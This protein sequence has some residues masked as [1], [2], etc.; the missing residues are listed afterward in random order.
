MMRSAPFICFSKAELY[1][2]ALCAIGRGFRGGFKPY[3]FSEST[4]LSGIPIASEMS[5]VEA[6]WRFNKRIIRTSLSV[7]FVA[8]L[9]IYLWLDSTFKAYCRFIIRA[10]GASS[11]SL[12]FVGL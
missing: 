8:M 11:K 12:S 6:L 9:A 4:E 3:S 1:V 2:A 10:A 5:L 7:Y